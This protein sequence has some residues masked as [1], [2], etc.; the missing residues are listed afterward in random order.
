MFDLSIENYEKKKKKKSKVVECLTSK[1]KVQNVQ[2]LKQSV[3]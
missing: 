1:V 3:Q 2:I